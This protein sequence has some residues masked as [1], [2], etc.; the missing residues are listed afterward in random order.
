M[1]HGPGGVIQYFRV[2]DAKS[3][4]GKR[5]TMDVPW[6]VPDY[7]REF[8]CKGG[9]CRHTCCAFWPIAVS[10]EEYFR[11]IGMSCSGQLHHQIES[12]LH[13]A[14][15]PTRAYYAQITPNWQGECPMHRPDGWCQLQ[16]EGGEEALPE[17]CRVYPR[18]LQWD[19]VRRVCVCSASC[20]AV[21]EQLLHREAPL[22][23]ETEMIA[24][25]HPELRE[26]VPVGATE[27]LRQLILLLQNR[28]LPL[29][30]RLRAAGA[31]LGDD[32]GAPGDPREAL[33]SIVAMA[34]G[35]RTVSLS[36]QY[37]LGG[38][39]ERYEDDADAARWAA[40]AALLERL[41]PDWAI[42]LEHLLCNHLCYDCFPYGDPRLSRAE[43]YRALAVLYALLRLLCVGLCA[44]AADE[45]IGEREEH[46]VDGLAGA[47][48]FVEHTPFAFNA[49]HDLHRRGLRAGTL[50]AL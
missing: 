50:L 2:R 5:C 1:Y 37:F 12:A 22:R 30:E 43:A 26:H 42:L 39:P 19:G 24:G 7:Y 10:M 9:A 48:R 4:N 41:L 27:E 28:A 49:A 21:V 11:L 17:L 40:D 47:F 35:M 33:R 38:L 32:P 46:L 3:V 13:M 45:E 25:R 6:L 8:R 31:L 34:K 16:L 18:S 44:E 15:Q 14:E 23:L 29:P 20:E 36:L